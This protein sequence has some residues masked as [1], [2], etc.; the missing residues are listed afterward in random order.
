M[1]ENMRSRAEKTCF[2]QG[3][4]L[5]PQQSP[6]LW[7]GGSTLCPMRDWACGFRDAQILRL[8]GSRLPDGGHFGAGQPGALLYTGP[9]PA[10]AA[11]HLH[12][13]PQLRETHL[14]AERSTPQAP[15]RISRAD[16]DPRRPRDPQASP[17]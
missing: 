9:W 5:F 8:R 2:E 10:K 11:C 7:I 1:L 3:F 4:L 15:A 13:V 6:Q 16:V 17:R 14:P 12:L